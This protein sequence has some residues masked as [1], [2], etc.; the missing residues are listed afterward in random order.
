[1]FGFGTL[2]GVIQDEFLEFVDVIRDLFWNALCVNRWSN[3]SPWHLVLW[4]PALYVNFSDINIQVIYG[5]G[6]L[7]GVLQDEFFEFV[8]MFMNYSELFLKCIVGTQILQYPELAPDISN[9][10]PLR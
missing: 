7:R 4:D 10:D 6:I 9:L 5:F 2:Q 1:M 8:D 3:T